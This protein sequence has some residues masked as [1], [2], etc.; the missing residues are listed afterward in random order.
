MTIFVNRGSYPAVTV[1]SNS[2]SV[3]VKDWEW[4]VKTDPYC[5]TCER[6]RA[7]LIIH[8]SSTRIGEA[9]VTAVSN[10]NLKDASSFRVKVEN[11][12]K[13]DI[14][15]NGSDG[16]LVSIV[17]GEPYGFTL[18]SSG[19]RACQLTAPGGVSGTDLSGIYERIW[20]GHPWYPEIGKSVTI[21]FSCTDGTYSVTDQITIRAT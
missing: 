9:T 21:T 5:P 18:N 2:S 10:S 17:Y 6:V 3:S 4:S 8:Y 14:K 12:V 7:D 19:A 15:V 20:P 1:V 16:P 13:A 11:P